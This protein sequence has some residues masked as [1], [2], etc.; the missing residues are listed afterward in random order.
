MAVTILSGGPGSA[1]W[2]PFLLMLAA[3][4]GIWYGA[5]K[6]F[7]FLKAKWRRRKHHAAADGH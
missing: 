5:E 7:Q 3:L 2:V 6:L 1:N 4:V